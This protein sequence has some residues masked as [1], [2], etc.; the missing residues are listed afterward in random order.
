[1]D[2]EQESLF[3]A[4][5]NHDWFTKSDGDVES[6]TG[7]FGWT[8]NHPSDWFEVAQNFIE[9]ITD[10]GDMKPPE[11]FIGVFWASID[12]NGIIH[13][14]KLGGVDVVAGS[15]W[16]MRNNPAVTA[17]KARFTATSLEYFDWDKD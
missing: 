3:K 5:L 6:P 13:I 15:M 9:V 7:Y 2:T 4:M 11:W 16:D 12:S 10:P 17:A 14:E 8:V 1:M